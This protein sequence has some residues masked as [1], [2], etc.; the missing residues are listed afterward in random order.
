MSLVRIFSLPTLVVFRPTLVF[1]VILFKNMQKKWPFFKLVFKPVIEALCLGV[2]K[3]P[4]HSISCKTACAPVKISTLC[5]AKDPK[6]LQ[7]D[8]EDSDQTA[9]LDRLI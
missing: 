7:V 4:G 6:R 2:S 1:L 8:S 3:E 9:R 5:V